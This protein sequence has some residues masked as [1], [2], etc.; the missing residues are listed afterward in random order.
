MMIGTAGHIDHG[1]TSLVR[2]LTGVDTDRLPE[3]K[4]RGMSIELG[5]AFM[6]AADGDGQIGF[7]DVP[8]HEKLL[9]T[10]I[11]GATGIDFGL[12]LV[13]ADDGVM[14]QTQ[15]HLAV[16]SLLG[17][18][19]GAVALT[20]IDRVEPERVQQVQAEIEALLADSSLAGASVWPVSAVSGE[21]IDAL[22]AYLQHEAQALRGSP[23]EAVDARSAS[24]GSSTQTQQTQTQSQN[25][26]QIQSPRRSADTDMG[27]GTLADAPPARPVK[28]FRLAMDR[29]FSLD[30]VGTVVTGT[31][32]AGEVRVGDVLQQQPGDTQEIRVRS[33]HAQNTPTQRAYAGQR[34]AIGLAGIERDALERGH[35]LTQRG[36]DS[37]S[38][39]F[40]VELQLWKA[41][42]KALRSGTRVHLHLGTTQCTASVALLD[43][44]VLAPGQRGLVQLVLSR[45]LAGWHGDRLI[46][47]DASGQRI[48]AGGRIL[49]S[50]APARYR[51]TPQRL[52]V[53]AALQQQGLRAQLAALLPAVGQLGLDLRQWQQTLGLADV[54]VLDELLSASPSP[55]L[56]H[57]RLGEHFVMAEGAFQALRADILKT[58]ADY[59]EQAT[60]EIGPDVAR[61]RR[62]SRCRLDDAHWRALLDQLAG[63][64]DLVISG[65]FVHLPDHGTEL[66]ARDEAVLLRVLPLMQQ[67]GAQGAWLRD[68][69]EAL[70]ETPANLRVS[71]AR[72]ARSGRIHQVIRD[73]YLDADT[74]TGLAAI[75]RR[76]GA[77]EGQDPKRPLLTVADFRDAS[78]LGRK[79]AVQ[80]ME[81]F[82]RI[83]LCR[84]V[85]DQHVIRLDSR[86]FLDDTP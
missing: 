67:A 48:L 47:R 18:G 2:A 11:A 28:G 57:R 59:H 71:L 23:Q 76:L 9:H 29:V 82:D 75:V 41:E 58:L 15:E 53:L 1:K 83:G 72:L 73:L 66:A 65:A 86:I 36:L 63:A 84:R 74:V 24:S 39:R 85:G 12:L 3:E 64:H 78:G 34:C 42:S 70:H 19:C 44:D 26:T 80:L 30:G 8:G 20:K 17:I 32:H 16:L 40:D 79:R 21:G 46:L 52:H 68:M 22:R 6:P 27:H 43:R 61:L 77:A 81:F 69:A 37:V 31:V 55:S 45:P 10:M 13:A 25:Q 38:D 54:A 7:I 35:W 14:P 62:L 56:A 50:R 51:R 4:Q 60:D 5:F 49:D 33:L